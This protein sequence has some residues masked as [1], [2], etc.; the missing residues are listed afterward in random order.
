MVELGRGVGVAAW[1]ETTEEVVLLV[2]AAE[3][4]GD[5]ELR[6][7]LFR[8]VWT[9]LLGKASSLSTKNVST[10]RPWAARS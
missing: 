10:L 4:E 9:K 5:E 1:L 7:G 2:G 8:K 6:V 3:E